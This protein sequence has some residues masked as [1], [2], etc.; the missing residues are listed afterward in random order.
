MLIAQVC[1]SHSFDNLPGLAMVEG[2]EPDSRDP[3]AGA[4]DQAGGGLPDPGRIT[5]HHK[6][7][8]PSGAADKPAC[9]DSFQLPFR[10]Q[11]SFVII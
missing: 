8:D 2:T 10:A 4:P 3:G 9:S 5:G 1:G 11:V 7:R 6:V